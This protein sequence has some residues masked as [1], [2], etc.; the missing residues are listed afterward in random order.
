MKITRPNFS[1]SSKDKKMKNKTM[2]LMLFP[3]IASLFPLSSSAIGLLVGVENQIWRCNDVFSLMPSFTPFINHTE[4]IMSITVDHNSSQIIA[5]DEEGNFVRASLSHNFQPPIIIGASPGDG[6]DVVFNEINS[7]MYFTRGTQVGKFDSHIS[8]VKDKK[9]LFTVAVD[10]VGG[11]VLVGDD[12]RN[13]D[14][15]D[16][17][18]SWQGTWERGFFG[19]DKPSGDLFV[20]G[21]KL[22][23]CEL[24]KDRIASVPLNHLRSPAVEIRENLEQVTSFTIDEESDLLF[25][26][27]EEGR[28]WMYSLQDNSSQVLIQSFDGSLRGKEG[29]GI[30]EVIFFL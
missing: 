6:R 26:T 15:Y 3:L 5:I 18:L 30:W 10:R 24:G 2:V 25:Y 13:I 27:S 4:K 28:I 7:V 23:W 29:G 14:V 22:Y 1:I 19:D 9:S 11:R 12:Q 21:E 20:K 17:S 8:T 16:W